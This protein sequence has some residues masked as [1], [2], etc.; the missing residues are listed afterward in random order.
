MRCRGYE[1]WA[2]CA[3]I[4]LTV[5]FTIFLDRGVCGRRFQKMSPCL[6]FAPSSGAVAE[7]WWHIDSVH[8]LRC[9]EG[10]DALLSQQ[11]CFKISYGSLSRGPYS[12][13]TSQYDRIAMWLPKSLWYGLPVIGIVLIYVMV[14]NAHHA[15][16]WVKRKS[17][18]RAAAALETR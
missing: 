6:P 11:L 2:A 8:P 4:S 13:T 18:R 14:L 17:A 7:S 5:C 16:A 12:S 9:S 1:R 10:T 15:L 3:E